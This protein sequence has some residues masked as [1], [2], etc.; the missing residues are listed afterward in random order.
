MEK[1][2]RGAALLAA[3]QT[4]LYHLISVGNHVGS[5]FTTFPQRYKI[6]L[7]SI[8]L[9]LLARI[10][11][12]EP[13]KILVYRS[14]LLALAHCAVHL[15]PAAGSFALIALNFQGRFIGAELQGAH[16]ATDD[17]KLAL[18]Q[19]AAKLHEL[20]II[21]SL[22]TIIFHVLRLDLIFGHGVPLGL[23]GSGWS[24][25]Q[26]T[27]FFS[28]EFWGGAWAKK[29]GR[30]WTEYRLVPLVFV[31]GLIATFAGPSTAVLA[32]PRVSPWPIGGGSYWLNGSEAQL[33]PT[34]VDGDMLQSYNCSTAESQIYDPKCPSAG[35][36]FLFQHFKTWWQYPDM[37]ALMEFNAKDYSMTKRIYAFVGEDTNFDTYAFTTHWA[38]AM[39]QDAKRDQFD[40]SLTSLRDHHRWDPPYPGYLD[41]SDQQTHSVHALLPLVRTA[42]L[43]NQ[44]IDITAE[45]L[46]QPIPLAVPAR[47]DI[48]NVP[49]NRSTNTMG[50]AVP[51]VWESVDAAGTIRQYFQDKGYLVAQQDGNMMLSDTTPSVVALPLDYDSLW[52]GLVILM[53]KP[54]TAT[55]D[56]FTCTMGGFWRPGQSIIEATARSNRGYHGIFKDRVRNV[57]TTDLKAIDGGIIDDWRPIHMDPSWYDLVSPTMADSDGF[58][59]LSPGRAASATRRSLME[60]LLEVVL[61]PLYDSPIDGLPAIRSLEYAISA[62]LVDGLSRSGGSMQN[63][64]RGVVGSDTF[65]P[66][67]DNM[68]RTLV[69]KG[70]PSLK[71]AAGK[72]ELLK[73]HDATEMLMKTVFT[74]YL[75]ATLGSFDYFAVAVLL[76]HAAMALTYTVLVF[77]WH[78]EIM[79]AMDTIPEMVAMAQNSPPPEYDGLQN[80]CAGIRSMKTLG[81]VAIIETSQALDGSDGKEELILRFQDT[82]R[83]GRYIPEV[84]QKYGG[85][86]TMYI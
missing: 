8:G 70:S 75:L 36:D 14:R 38:T 76:L 71:G 33:W 12:E 57:V 45:T 26:A 69:F 85:I 34:K 74:G 19:V 39:L 51:Y 53:N 52:L 22:S 54:G 86:K 81:R 78:P 47:V 28:L 2:K 4:V 9:G 59:S 62:Y 10:K 18:I 32:S 40:R 58:S 60:R 6:L 29:P 48:W 27:W 68:A 44:A 25:A 35:Y 7:R 64:I 15:I 83:D 42:C 56:A 72:P 49:R 20:L 3:L 23:I 77:W 73:D 5:F 16:W 11:G 61:Y 66:S 82:A 55:F 13:R 79:E 30:S 21:A 31:S 17:V 84:G 50:S 1:K 67:D 65:N 63:N 46:E 80:S 37:H 41:L 43:K 24:F